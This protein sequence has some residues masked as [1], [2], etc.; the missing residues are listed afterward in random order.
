MWLWIQKKK[1]KSIFQLMV[2]EVARYVT[3]SQLVFNTRNHVDTLRDSIKLKQDN[4]NIRMVN[5]IFSMEVISLLFQQLKTKLELTW[6][7]RG[8][9]TAVWTHLIRCTLLAFVLSMV[10][11]GFFHIY[12]NKNYAWI[13]LKWSCFECLKFVFGTQNN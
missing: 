6:L 3:L 2:C 5:T 9:I 11:S 1:T 7:L 13:F 8:F 12:K 4:I 10:F